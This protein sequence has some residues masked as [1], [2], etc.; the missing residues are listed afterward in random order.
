MRFVRREGCPLFETSLHG[1]EDADWGRRVPGKPG[2]SNAP[3]L[4]LDHVGVIRYFKKKAYYSK[5][6]RKYQERNPDD[7]MKAY[8][9]LT[10]NSGAYEIKGDSIIFN[11]M[12]AKSPNYMNDAPNVARHYTLDGDKLVLQAKRG[13]AVSVTTLQR[14]K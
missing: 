1:P 2:I 12:V 13:E 11:V 14:L 9:Y 5:S 6:M 3:L 7:I 8:R 10:S 4:H